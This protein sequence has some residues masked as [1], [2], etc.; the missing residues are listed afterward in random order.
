M[1]GLL[2]KVPVEAGVERLKVVGHTKDGGETSLWYWIDKKM[3]VQILIGLFKLN[4]N[5]FFNISNFFSIYFSFSVPMG[6]SSRRHQSPGNYLKSLNCHVSLKF[7][8]IR[9]NLINSRSKNS[10]EKFWL[11][12]WQIDTRFIYY[13]SWY[14]MKLIDLSSSFTWWWLSR[15]FPCQLLIIKLLFFFKYFNFINYFLIMQ[16]WWIRRRFALTHKIKY[17]QNEIN[18]FVNTT[19]KFYFL[20]NKQGVRYIYNST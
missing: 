14:F 3:E 13:S 10:E 8:L 18:S 5:I 7:N 19:D 2:S 1:V 6:M 11:F 12:A 15:A 9:D 17:F 20:M 16:K 4:K